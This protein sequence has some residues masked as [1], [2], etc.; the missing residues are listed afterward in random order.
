MRMLKLL[1]ALP[2]QFSKELK[3]FGVSPSPE[4]VAALLRAD[5]ELA[6]LENL[7]LDLQLLAKTFVDKTSCEVSDAQIEGDTAQIGRAHV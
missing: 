4:Q 7:G 3:E 1:W 2:L 5:T 6:Q